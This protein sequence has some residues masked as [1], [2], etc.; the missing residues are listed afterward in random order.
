MRKVLLCILDGW[1]LG[2]K[3]K[4]NSIEVAK[5]K[6]FDAI[7]KKFD[8]GKLYASEKKVG[9]PS[10]QFGNSE[11]GHMNIGGGR[12]ILQDILRIDK[13]LKNGD[14]ENNY[15]F[16]K[17]HQE[18]QRVHLLGILSAGGV[19]GHQNHLFKIIEILGKKKKKF[20]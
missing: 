16:L 1:G 11:V 6:N 5:T 2:K 19:H 17:M 7:V 10:G 9:L 13:S 8:M 15:N 18:S 3:D 20:F 12:I 14:I 4:Y